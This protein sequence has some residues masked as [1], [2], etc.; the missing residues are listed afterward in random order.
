MQEGVPT[1]VRSLQAV[2]DRMHEVITT[3]GIFQNLFMSHVP[4]I[5]RRFFVRSFLTELIGRDQCTAQV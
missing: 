2:Q 4:V 1:E 3:V 5:A